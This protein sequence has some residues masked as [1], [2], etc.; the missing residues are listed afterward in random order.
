MSTHDD[1]LRAIGRIEGEL[2]EIRKLSQR[3][4]TLELWQSWLKGGWAAVVA[5]YVYLCRVV[6]AR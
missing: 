6:S 3:V 4:S 5:M 1:I 2:M